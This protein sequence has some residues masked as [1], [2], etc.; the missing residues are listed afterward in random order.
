MN[1]NTENRILLSEDSLKHL[2]QDIPIDIIEKLSVLKD[3][4]YHRY[5]D[6]NS[7]VQGLLGERII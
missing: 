6:F 5:D 3:Q 4:I 1:G 2:A 7:I